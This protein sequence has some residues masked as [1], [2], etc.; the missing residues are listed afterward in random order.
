MRISYS[1]SSSPPAGPITWTRRVPSCGCETQLVSR[2]RQGVHPTQAGQLLADHADAILARLALAEEQV[3]EVVGLRR[4]RVR[5]GSFFTAL[6]YLSAE[7][8]AFYWTPDLSQRP[9]FKADAD[10]D[11]DWLARQFADRPKVPVRFYIDVGFLEPQVMLNSNRRL[12]DVLR[13]RGYEV[14]YQEYNGMHDY[15]PWRGTLA[16]DGHP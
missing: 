4:G 14:T 8:G 9:I 2:T 7:A 6:V 13:A 11:S 1:T 15:L 3:A 12:R 5:L 16:V 10:D